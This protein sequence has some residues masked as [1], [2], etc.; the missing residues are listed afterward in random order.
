M[1]DHARAAA[2]SQCSSSLLCELST[3][4]MLGDDMAAFA[5]EPGSTVALSW[6]SCLLCEAAFAQVTARASFVELF[7]QLKFEAS[8]SLEWCGRFCLRARQRT[9]LVAGVV[10]ATRSRRLHSQELFLST[11]HECIELCCG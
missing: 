5:L 3:I 8:D 4:C 6:R 9:S 1:G 11:V 7:I 10:P 2:H